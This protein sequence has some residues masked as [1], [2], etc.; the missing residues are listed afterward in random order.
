MQGNV[1]QSGSMAFAKDG[2]YHMLLTREDTQTEDSSERGGVLPRIT[3]V[4]REVAVVLL[5]ATILFIVANVV[6]ALAYSVG[7]L[8]RN[9]TGAASAPM[10]YK[11][12]HPSLAGVY[13][14]MSKEEISQLLLDTRR[15]PQ[16]YDSYTQFKEPAY[17][18][19]YVNVSP[20]GFRVSKN[21]GQ[22]PV[23]GNQLTIFM[24]G[25]ST[26]FGYGVSDD[27]TIPSHLQEFLG[28]RILRPV[29]VYNFGR[30]AYFSV[31]ERIF[32]E[33]LILDG[34]IPDL[35]IFL[36]GLN[37]FVHV[38][39]EPGY[40]PDL[41][42]FMLERD[43]PLSKR[44]ALALPLA[45]PFLALPEDIDGK[46]ASSTTNR[47]DVDRENSLQRVIGRYRANKEIAESI[48]R[49]FNIT[50]L[51]VWQPIPLYAYDRKYHIF[52]EFNYNEF[53]PHVEPGFRLMA[54]V[55]KSESMG[56]DFLWLG[57]MQ[58]NLKE[59][60][61]VDAFHYNGKMSKL[62]AERIGTTVLERVAL[63]RMHSSLMED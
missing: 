13:P 31:Q 24:F 4:Y 29:R 37:D 17:K 44:I 25:G 54:Q 18:S 8:F 43:V 51:F 27:Q 40:T 39:G 22:W 26:T 46:K 41:A 55:V 16:V 36:D 34:H 23:S 38:N 60:V 2:S 59:P 61:Y 28:T 14:D 9:R 7:D 5:N 32:L 35:V 49:G 30:C 47:E 48:C 52:S 42:K 50:P 12:F 21:Q 62:I 15:I 10:K 6:V 56:D 63:R 57:D 33:K 20:V 45:K 1:I 3:R 53:A 58:Q 11:D 19:K